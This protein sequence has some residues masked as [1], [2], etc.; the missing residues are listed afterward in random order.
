MA[1]PAKTSLTT[2][3]PIIIV[4]ALALWLVAAASLD[5]L[6]SNLA[7][8]QDSRMRFTLDGLRTRLQSG[9]EL[10]A[11]FAAAGG[12]QALL[13]QAIRADGAITSIRVA[14]P[15]GA[16]IFDSSAPERDAPLSRTLTLGAPL[17]GDA[18]ERMGAV[19]L[20]YDSGPVLAAV[21]SAR[22]WLALGV[23]LALAAIGACA[24]VG[25]R[26]LARASSR[27]FDAMA[28][29]LEAPDPHAQP[30]PGLLLLDQARQAARTAAHEVNAA[31]GQLSCRE[32]M[33]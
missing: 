1:T 20:R 30:D 7:G 33:Q 11:G 27:R 22:R 6:Q 16:I 19:F 26:M 2:T 15:D 28:R 23:A 12:A 32:P 13:D 21:Q 14:D 4:S 9:M 18:G 25:F 10:E 8:V 17:T 31:R 24:L 5:H 3:A 29:Q